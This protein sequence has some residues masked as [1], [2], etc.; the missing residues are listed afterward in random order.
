MA[1]HHG[2]FGHPLDRDI[3]GIREAH[4]TTDTD[5]E[6]TQDFHPVETD[7]FEDLEHNDPAKL[8]AFMRELMFYIIEFRLGEDSPQ[9]LCII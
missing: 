1:T 7:N 8:T 4:K 2:D 6:N 3:N 5:I 9:K